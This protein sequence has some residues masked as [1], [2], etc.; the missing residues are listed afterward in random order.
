MTAWTEA[1]VTS[2]LSPQ[3]AAGTVE[4]LTEPLAAKGMKV[5]AVTDQAPRPAKPG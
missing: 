4:R 3:P 2:K 1:Q 5:F